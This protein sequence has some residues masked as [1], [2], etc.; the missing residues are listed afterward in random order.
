MIVIVDYGMGNL[1]SMANMLRKVGAAAVVSSE[2]ATVARAE[3][4]ILPGVGAFDAGM[5][6]LTERGLVPLLQERVAAGTPTLGV[7]L[8]MQLFAQASE[9][10]QLP[11]LGWIDGRATRFRPNGD[12]RLKVPHMGWNVV[13]PVREHPLFADMPDEMRFYFVHSYHVVCG[14]ER[15]S[16]ARATYGGDFVAAVARDNVVGVQ[17]HPEKSHKF[18]MRLL[19]N[20]A[21]RC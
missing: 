20:F 5:R 17:F 21:E 18:G 13:Q 10:G 4:L 15:I 19:R 8:G 12:A 7:C 1:G 11:G 9:E 6:Q 2:P 14:D 3:K 16:L